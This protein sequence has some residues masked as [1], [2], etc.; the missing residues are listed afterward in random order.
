MSKRKKANPNEPD[1]L[2]EEM[3]PFGRP[4]E[5][6]MVRTQIYLTRSEHDFL[7][8]EAARR[9]EPM[10][11]VIRSIIDDR[12][13]V[14]EDAWANNPLLEPTPETPGWKGHEDGVLNHDHYIYGS[15]KKYHKMN[16]EWVPIS[17]EEI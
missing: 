16:G 5:A 9:G 7:Q 10:S 6:S 14:P 4:P 1:E 11:A 15:P 13:T 12:M 3:L 2:K 8:S 17:P